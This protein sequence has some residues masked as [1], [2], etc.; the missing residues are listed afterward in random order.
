MD[1][2][3]DDLKIVLRVFVRYKPSALTRADFKRYLNTFC[4]Q[5]NSMSL[6]KISSILN[7]LWRAGF[8]EKNLAACNET[9]IE[10][11]SKGYSSDNKKGI[12]HKAQSYTLTDQGLQLAE[13]LV[14]KDWLVFE[15]DAIKI[16]NPLSDI[17]QGGIPQGKTSLA[18]KSFKDLK[19]F[20][21]AFKEGCFQASDLE[22]N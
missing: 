2:Q 19:G 6:Q 17:L 15:Q 18:S 7:Q 4:W 14:G 22:Q 8:V 20:Q 1:A 21:T 9:E 5:E 10:Y 3:Q 12:V 13:Q 11:I 16:P